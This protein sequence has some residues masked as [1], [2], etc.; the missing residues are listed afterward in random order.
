MWQQS[1]RSGAALQSEATG[2]PPISIVVPHWHEASQ[3]CTA[4]VQ[5]LLCLATCVGHCSLFDKGYHG[6]LHRLR[7]CSHGCLDGGPDVTC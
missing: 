6:T 1:V 4:L 7:P 5:R 2:G 3:V